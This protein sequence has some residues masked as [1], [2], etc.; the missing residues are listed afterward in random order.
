MRIGLKYFENILQKSQI[1][2]FAQQVAQNL[3]RN[4]QMLTPHPKIFL[5]SRGT[6]F[7]IHLL[8]VFQF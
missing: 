3:Y 5:D 2:T 1:A 7:S 6:T 4:K 8:L